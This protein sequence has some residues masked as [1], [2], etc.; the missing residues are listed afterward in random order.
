MSVI[1]WNALL[2]LFQ[3]YNENYWYDVKPSIKIIPAGKK[4]LGRLW[5]D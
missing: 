3:L 2:R 5:Y 4:T 1:V